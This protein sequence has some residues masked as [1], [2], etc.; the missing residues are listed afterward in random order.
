MDVD[1][2]NSDGGDVVDVCAEFGECDHIYEFPSLVE[3]KGETD[4]E[5]EGDVG[6]VEI[7]EGADVRFEQVYPDKELP[8]YRY[9]H[10]MNFLPSQSFSRT[11][12]NSRSVIV[13]ERGRKIDPNSLKKSAN[14]T[15]DDDEGG[16]EDQDVGGS[17]NMEAVTL[18]DNDSI[19]LMIALEGRNINKFIG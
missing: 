10:E 9:S 19:N 8:Y 6:G 17:S 11:I 18:A 15:D 13:D 4:E 12:S 5:D 7:P 16:Y 3:E 1:S 2:T 14:V